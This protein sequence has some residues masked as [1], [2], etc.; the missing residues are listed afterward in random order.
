MRKIHIIILVFSLA[1]ASC[2]PSDKLTVLHLNDTHSHIDVERGGEYE[3]LGG[4]I[5]RAAYIDSVRAADGSRN[6][7][8]MHAGDFS[9]GTSYFSELNGDIEIDLLNALGYD[10][11]TVGNHEFDNGVEELARRLASLECPAVCANYDFT[12]TSLEPYIKPYVILKKAGRKIGVIGVTTNLSRVVDVNLIEGLEYEDPSIST[13]A[14]ADYLKNS[15]G[16]DYVIVLSHLGHS[17]DVRLAKK[18]SKVDIIVGGH[19]HTRLD[20]PERVK[21]LDGKEV[22]IVQDGEWGIE[23]G[24]LHLHF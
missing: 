11:V 17:S 19:S 2:K 14:Y 9:Q 1:L 8:L 6:V 12:G 21:D 5:E 13:N 16:C 3:G 7:L 22:I 18:S 10:V 20:E 15:E 23:V 4:V 24:T